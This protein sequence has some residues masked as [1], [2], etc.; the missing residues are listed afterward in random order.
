M[1][2]RTVSFSHVFLDCL[3]LG[4]TIDTPSVRNVAAKLAILKG[5]RRKATAEE[6]RD[7]W[8]HNIW[9]HAGMKLAGS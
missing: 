9:N 6:H 8:G 5:D 3:P 2:V 7:N 1:I 4:R